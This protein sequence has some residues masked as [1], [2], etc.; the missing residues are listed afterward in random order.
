MNLFIFYLKK[1]G[2]QVGSVGG[3]AGNHRLY[4]KILKLKFV[5]VSLKQ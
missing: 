1:N 5:F 4:S 3:L 2:G